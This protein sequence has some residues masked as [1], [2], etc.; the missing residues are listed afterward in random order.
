MGTTKSL[1]HEKPPIDLAGMM[2]RYLPAG[3]LTLVDQVTKAANKKRKRVY[4]VGG[5]VRDLILQRPCLDI[6]LVLEGDAID[7]GKTLDRGEGKLTVHPAFGTATLKGEG[8]TLDLVTARRE[9][10]PRPGALPEVT[11]GTLNE[12]LFRRDFT[13]NAMA[14][15]LTGPQR[16]TLVDPWGGMAD[17]EARLVRVLHDKS[18]V[19]DATR[20]LR[21]LRY[22]QR[23]GFKL[24]NST[25]F[26]LKRDIPRLDDISGDR[27]RHELNR[28]FEELSPELAVRRGGQFGVWKRLHARLKGDSWVTNS[29]QRARDLL[30]PTPVVLYYA[31]FL[32]R[33]KE[34]EASDLLNRLAAPKLTTTVVLDTISLK[35][36]LGTLAVDNIK[37][38]QVFAAL[39]NLSAQ[40]VFANIAATANTGTKKSLKL[41]LEKLRYVRPSLR[42]DD[43]VRMGVTPGPEVGQLLSKLHQHKLDGE[44]SGKAAEVKLVRRLQSDF[45]TRKVKRARIK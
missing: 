21:A 19:D 16:G 30:Q 25:E 2:A 5:V 24:E 17:I 9:T 32:Y 29:F 6:D 14:I 12:D 35:T 40:S 7:L 39:R 1:A 10:Y 20:I 11:P 41:Y 36:G 15:A 31:L 42:G 23:L 18:F 38:S 34:E 44:V 45:H 13:I 33:L 4:L 22:E 43:L 28:I 8:F 27:I 3:A 26:L 37:P